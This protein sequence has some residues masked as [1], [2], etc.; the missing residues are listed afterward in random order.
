[1]AEKEIIC[2]SSIQ[3]TGF[4]SFSD[5]YKFCHEWLT[6][7]TGLNI[8]EDKY[9]EKLIGDVKN[10]EIKWTG[11]REVTDYFKFQVEV[12]FDISGLKNVE[13]TQNGKKV[14]INQGGVKMSVKG[15]LIRD[16]KGKFERSALQKFMRGI[17]EK[18]VIHSRIEQF[19]G[20]LA[21]DC[22]EFLNQAKAYLDLE[23]KK[24]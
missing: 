12:K 16:Y 2:S 10:I 23:G 6:E 14:K 21:G 5:F 13:V 22:N 8:S 11:A 7:E 19:E 18:W 20:K 4:F 24:G 3:Y 15:I 9:K 17:Y 1:M